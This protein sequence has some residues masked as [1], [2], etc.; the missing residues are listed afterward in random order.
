MMCPE[1][2]LYFEAVGLLLLVEL[3]VRKEASAAM[4]MVAAVSFTVLVSSCSS[5]PRPASLTAKK[6]CFWGLQHP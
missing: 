1:V 5:M 3:L 2:M 4:S 6:N